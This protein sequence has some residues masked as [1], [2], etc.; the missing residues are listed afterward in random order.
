MIGAAR[1]MLSYDGVRA[2]P[3]V[4]TV[5]RAMVN[6]RAGR[7]PARSAKAPMSTPPTGRAKNPT[8]NT[9][10]DSSRLPIGVDAG[11]KVLPMYTAKN[12]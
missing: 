8:P 1:P 9:A 4:P 10:T 11:K 12:A 2:R 6:S 3:S 5:M 7:R